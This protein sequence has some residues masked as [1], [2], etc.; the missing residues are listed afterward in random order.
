MNKEQLT[1]FTS[2]TNGGLDILEHYISSKFEI[3]VLTQ[4]E[5]NPDLSFLIDFSDKYGNYTVTLFENNRLKKTYHPVWF[6]KEFIYNSDEELTYQLINRD[7]NLGLIE[8]KTPR[9]LEIQ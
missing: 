4:S 2:A 7:M 5:A 6:V 9:K 8:S 3:G 1:K